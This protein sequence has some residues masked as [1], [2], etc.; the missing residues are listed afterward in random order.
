MKLIFWGLIFLFFDFK[1]NF[2]SSSISLLPT[3][4]G[5]ALICSGMGRVEEC[6]TYAKSR[7]WVIAGIVYSAV[8]WVLNC[9]GAQFDAMVSLLLSLVSSVLQLVTT[10]RIAAGVC[11]LERVCKYDLYGR[12][13][14]TAWIVLLVWTVLVQATAWLGI[15]AL[16]VVA[17]VAAMV[18]M[19]YYI[20]RFHKSRKAYE[21]QAGWPEE[22]YEA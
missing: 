1:L 11:E 14:K 22:T 6:E 20:F 17:L 3:F 8:M 10:Y 19:V 13:L 7:T 2:G 21:E 5:Y 9:V 18:F 4:A 16:A 15:V 12:S